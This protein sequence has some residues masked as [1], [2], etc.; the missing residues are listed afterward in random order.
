MPGQEL[1]QPNPPP[2][3]SRL[4]ESVG[5]LRVEL[6]LNVLNDEELNA[7]KLFRRAADYIA[8]CKMIFLR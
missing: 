5:S 3:K 8:A 6:E 1:A 7:V 2:E 4:P